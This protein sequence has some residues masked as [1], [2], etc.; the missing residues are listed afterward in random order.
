MNISILASYKQD[1]KWSDT[2]KYRL[3]TRPDVWYNA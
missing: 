2:T 3:T 1:V